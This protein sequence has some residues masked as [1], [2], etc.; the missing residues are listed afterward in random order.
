MVICAETKDSDHV[1]IVFGSAVAI[2]QCRLIQAIPERTDVNTGG[3][4]PKSACSFPND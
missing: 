2:A 1:K 4:P 3:H